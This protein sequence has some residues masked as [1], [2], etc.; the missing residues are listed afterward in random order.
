[1]T[2]CD[3]SFNV[4]NRKKLGE[5]K[6]RLAYNGKPTRDWISQEYKS[7]PTAHTESILLTAGVD[8]MEGREVMTHDISNVFVQSACSREPRW[9]TDRDE[10][11]GCAFGLVDRIRSFL[12][13]P[14]HGL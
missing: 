13:F 1:M 7:S 8:A 9:R 5:L 4:S 12:L 6:G 2:T 10:H 14:V 11:P 3:G